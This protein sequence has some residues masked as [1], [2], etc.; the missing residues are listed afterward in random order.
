MGKDMNADNFVNEENAD[1]FKMNSSSYMDN[2]K[3]IYHDLDC[4][5]VSNSSSSTDIEQYCFPIV[6]LIELLI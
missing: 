3:L 1:I 6:D 5:D 4:P 2:L